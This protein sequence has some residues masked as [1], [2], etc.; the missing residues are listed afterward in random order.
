MTNLAAARRGPSAM[1]LQLNRSF[2]NAALEYLSSAAL[3]H[4]ME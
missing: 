2:D 3:P 1:A 4:K